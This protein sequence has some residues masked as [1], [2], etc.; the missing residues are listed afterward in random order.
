MLIPFTRMSVRLVPFIAIIGSLQAIQFRVL[1]WDD[2]VAARKIAVV[3]AGKVTEVN[4]L[5]PLKRSEVYQGPQRCGL[6]IRTLAREPVDGK[7]VELTATVAA[8]IVRPLLLLLPDDSAPAGLRGLVI[9][10]DTTAFPWGSFRFLN[11]TGV[12]LV[13]QVEQR[14]ITIPGGWKPTNLAPGGPPR[15]VGVRIAAKADLAVPLYTSVWQLEDDVRRLIFIIPGTDTRLGQL[16]LKVIPE[17]KATAT[18]EFPADTP[19]ANPQVG[20]R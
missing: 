14:A 7:P 16:A 15:N 6:V 17:D 13:V 1:A 20:N 2:A 19:A 18:L 10:D 3:V 4:D 11:A 12:D 8:A 9:D 5:H